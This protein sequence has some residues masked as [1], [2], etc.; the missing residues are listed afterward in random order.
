MLP[1]FIRKKLFKLSWKLTVGS[2]ERY[3]LPKP[4]HYIIESHPILNSNLLNQLSHGRIHP[5]KNISEIKNK[6]IIF[7]D[8]KEEEYD[9]ITLGTGYKISFPFLK[10]D[11]FIF[12]NKIVDL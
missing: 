5:R 4:D 12:E 2:N 9:T 7:E 6:F 3:G 8:G 1:R 11:E 10:Y